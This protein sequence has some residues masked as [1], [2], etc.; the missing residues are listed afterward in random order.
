MKKPSTLRLLGALAGLGALTVV[1]AGSGAAS[2]S[3][4]HKSGATVITMNR[5]GKDLFFE[6]PATVA[7]GTQLKIKNKTNPRQIGPH[8]F[9]LVHEKDR[10]TSDSEIK[11]CEKK[12]ELICGEVVFGWHEAD[13][14]TFELGANP[15]EVGK[16]GWDKEGSFKHKGDSWVTMAKG[17][18]FSQKVTAEPGK[19]L[20]FMCV[21]H[22][23]MQG[24]ITVTEG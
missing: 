1:C 7:A 15:V 2:A 11:R 10:P 13:P 24:E 4:S 23:F 17:E 16:N 18:S 21:V 14:Q 19:V 12:L 8:T 22:P 6:G 20:H 9:S 3:T 5:D